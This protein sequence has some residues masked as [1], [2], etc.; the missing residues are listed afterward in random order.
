MAAV[1]IASYTTLN[2]TP[3]DHRADIRL[4]FRKLYSPSL[5]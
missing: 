4:S 3:K 1:T 2:T 5:G